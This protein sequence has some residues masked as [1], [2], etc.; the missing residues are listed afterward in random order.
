MANNIIRKLGVNVG[1]ARDIKN[2][3]ASIDKIKAFLDYIA[4]IDY[5]EMLEDELE[6]EE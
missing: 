3:I 1:L 2:A 5:P 4:I 6:E